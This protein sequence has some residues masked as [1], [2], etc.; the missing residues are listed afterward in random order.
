MSCYDVIESVF[1]GKLVETIP[2]ALKGWRIPQSECER[3]LRNK[4]LCIVDSIPVYKCVSENT[5]VKKI[6]YSKDGND[7]LKILIETP[8]G[9]ID[10]L[11]HLSENTDTSGTIYWQK[12]YIF[13]DSNDYGAIEYMIR[14]KKFIDDYGQFS[15]RRKIVGMDAFVT[16]RAPGSAL[17]EIMYDIMG[18]ER[19]SIEWNE[20]KEKVKRLY[21]AISENNQKIYHIVAKSP[22][23]IVK[24]GENY[25]PEVLGKERFMNY[26]LPHWKEVCIILHKENKM[27]GC[28]LDANNRLWSK[29]IGDSE[30][31]WIE[32]FTPFPD[33]DMTVSE[34]RRIWPG[35]VLFINFPSSVHLMDRDAIIETTKKIIKEAAPGD[36]FIL[37]IT[38]N[39]PINTW[40]KNFLAILET[41]NEY[42]K[43]P[44]K[45]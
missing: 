30:L 22:A 8:R 23:E 19:F 33:S 43:L 17:H 3:V 9:P 39:V 40:K 15:K 27:V 21:E 36:K 14:D 28:H 32:G 12:D 13:K 18:I 24:C 37:G 35:K 6:Y 16:T 26:I 20:R 34:A 38:E 44:I 41:I 29:E 45:L 25:T 31:D 1:K 42:G 4:G 7:F 10:S 2:F 5:E 11:F